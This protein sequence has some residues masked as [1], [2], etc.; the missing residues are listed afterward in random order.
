VCV[1]VVLSHKDTYKSIATHLQHMHITIV[2]TDKLVTPT[3][4]M[5]CYV[6]APTNSVRCHCFA[7]VTVTAATISIIT[8]NYILPLLMCDVCVKAAARCFITAP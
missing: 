7:H 6:T 4:A 8:A 5:L 1:Y 2:S 3:F